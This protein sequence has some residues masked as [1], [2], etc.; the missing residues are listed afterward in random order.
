MIEEFLMNDC[1]G[2]TERERK[3]NEIEVKRKNRTVHLHHQSVGVAECQ[4]IDE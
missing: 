1:V 3:R 4:E 2:N